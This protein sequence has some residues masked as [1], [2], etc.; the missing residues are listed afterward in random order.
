MSRT[1]TVTYRD[2]LAGLQ[3]YGV[4]PFRSAGYA[5]GI[6]AKLYAEPGIREVEVVEVVTASDIAA[7]F[8]W[9]SGD[10]TGGDE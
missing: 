2:D 7:Y 9:D 6:A 10:T 8:E 4:G 1:Y 5:D 3:R